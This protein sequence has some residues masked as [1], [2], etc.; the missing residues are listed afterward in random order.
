MSSQQKNTQNIP[1]DWHF[2]CRFQKPPW[3]LS[4]LSLVV[5]LTVAPPCRNKG[6]LPLLRSSFLFCLVGTIPYSFS[7]SISPS[8]EYSGLIFFRIWLEM[9]RRD[10]DA[11]HLFPLLLLFPR[12]KR[13]LVVNSSTGAHLSLASGNAKRK[14]ADSKCP[15]WSPSI[16]HCN[17]SWISC[18]G[19][20]VLYHCT[21]WEAQLNSWYYLLLY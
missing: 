16:S 4:G 8:N 17:V 10:K 1:P 19:R 6:N 5:R 21:T 7:F 14:L 18:I 9:F 11:L 20:Q 13:G 2:P 3:S 12:P 15:I